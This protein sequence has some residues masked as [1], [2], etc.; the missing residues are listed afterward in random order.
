MLARLLVGPM[1]MMLFVTVVLV[2]FVLLSF[3]NH[4]EFLSNTAHH[5]V[6]VLSVRHIFMYYLISADAY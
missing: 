3:L 4:P 1:V 2:L 5:A 6:A